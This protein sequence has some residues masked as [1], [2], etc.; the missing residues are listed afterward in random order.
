MQGLYNLLRQGINVLMCHYLALF[1]PNVTYNESNCIE[2]VHYPSFLCP[3]KYAI[4][5]RP[6][7]SDVL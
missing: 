2:S 7:G 1:I 5:H 4:Y 3:Y 6:P